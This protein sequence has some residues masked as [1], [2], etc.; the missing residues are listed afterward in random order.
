MP[1]VLLRREIPLSAVRRPKG[2]PKV[3]DCP[4]CDWPME[5]TAISLETNTIIYECENPD[6]QH[7]HKM[8]VW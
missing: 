7:L 5:L 6:C 1:R 2:I 4:M 8:R 3:A